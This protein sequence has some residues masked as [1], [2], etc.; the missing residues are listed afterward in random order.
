MPDV[1][2]SGLLLP[3]LLPLNEGASC[4]FQSRVEGRGFVEQFLTDQTLKMLSQN[5]DV[6]EIMLIWDAGEVLYPIVG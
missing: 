3:W 1:A 5:M 2:F 6:K 4:S